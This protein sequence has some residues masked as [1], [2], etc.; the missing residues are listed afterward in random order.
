MLSDN[1]TDSLLARGSLAVMLGE[2]SEFN[3][4]TEKYT[5]LAEGGK[6]YFSDA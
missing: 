3:A 1:L 5:P 2:G 6:H 4:G